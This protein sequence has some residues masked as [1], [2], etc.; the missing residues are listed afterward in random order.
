MTGGPGDARA[1]ERTLRVCER[2]SAHLDIV[3]LVQAPP[4]AML[5]LM[6]S[7]GVST[8]P[9]TYE[10]DYLN[11]L[12]EMARQRSVRADIEILNGPATL[13]VVRKVLRDGHDLL[14][15]AAQPSMAIR[16]LL[17]GHTDRQLIR[18]CP[19][20]VWIEKPS[21]G[22][23]H[24]RI[25]AAVDPAPFRDDPEFDPVREELNTCI[26]RMAGRVAQL[27]D[28]ELHVVHVC[29]SYMDQRLQHWAGLA[30]LTEDEVVTL[31]NP[32]G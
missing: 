28:A 3:G 4:S 18:K 5:R 31:A 13:E 15:K 12:L 17:F 19:C 9:P 1:F 8:E 22:V 14:V 25:L 6:E 32:L 24:G 2:E 26:L 29:R 20:P 27:E 7:F 30:G 16:H 23:C 11:Q 21:D 10:G